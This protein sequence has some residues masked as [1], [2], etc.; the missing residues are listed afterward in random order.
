MKL[1]GRDKK[2]IYKLIL[3]QEGARKWHLEFLAFEGLP[4]D[5]LHLWDTVKESRP[6][7][8]RDV[9]YLANI[10]ENQKLLVEKT[11]GDFIVSLEEYKES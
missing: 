6:G 2:K 5:D 8:G 3:T 7:K 1:I 11:L 4:Y 10:N 9:V